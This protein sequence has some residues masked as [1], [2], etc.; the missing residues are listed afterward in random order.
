MDVLRECDNTPPADPH[1]LSFLKPLM[2]SDSSRRF[3][4]L[5]PEI[6]HFFFF[7][8][9][10]KTIEGV[11]EKKNKQSRAW[12]SAR[13]GSPWHFCASCELTR[14]FTRAKTL[15]KPLAILISVDCSPLCSTLISW[16]TCSV[17][18]SLLSPSADCVLL[19][20]TPLL[21][22]LSPFVFS[23][24]FLPSS[25]YGLVGDLVRKPFVW[26]SRQNKQRDSLIGTYTQ[27]NGCHP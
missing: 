16:L 22:R 20:L 17:D 27:K 19:L 9:T 21:C 5:R 8:D 13:G 7:T 6:Y 26:V 18:K 25:T 12:V 23:R 2:A 1:Y 4:H 15:T 24:A 14:A 10:Q 3:S 11:E